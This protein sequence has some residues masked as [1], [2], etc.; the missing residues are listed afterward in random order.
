MKGY[1][2]YDFQNHQVLISRDV[3]FHFPSIEQIV[4]SNG[5]VDVA[6]EASPI[7]DIVGIY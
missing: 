5:Q 7:D 6:A 3:V 2:L 1:R 4:I